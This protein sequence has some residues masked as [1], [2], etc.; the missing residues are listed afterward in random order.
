VC[1]AWSYSF[2]AE[3]A[4]FLHACFELVDVRDGLATYSAVWAIMKV[5]ILLLAVFQSH[6]H[7]LR[8]ATRQWPH[9]HRTRRAQGVYNG[10]AGLELRF[11][12]IALLH[13]ERHITNTPRVPTAVVRFPIRTDICR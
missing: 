6:L 10:R 7:E 4:Q 12:C 2:D 9:Y 1:A 3:V 8:F 5:C 11:G 13:D